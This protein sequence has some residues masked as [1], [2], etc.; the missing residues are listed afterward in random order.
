MRKLFVSLICVLAGCGGIVKSNQTL[1][2]TSNVDPVTVTVNGFSCDTPC[3]L[4][5]PAGLDNLSVKMVVENK[6]TFKENTIERF[7]LQNLAILLIEAATGGGVY[8]NI[9]SQMLDMET[10]ELIKNIIN[11]ID[12]LLAKIRSISEK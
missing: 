10:A 2:F 6:L 8:V 3:S 4:T 5:I 11:N 12:E 1:S 9:L 7:F